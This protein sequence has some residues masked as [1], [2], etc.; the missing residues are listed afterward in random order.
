MQLW[1]GNH[2]GLLDDVFG[3]QKR[4]TGEIVTALSVE[5]GAAGPSPGDEHAPTPGYHTYLRALARYKSGTAV[6]IEASLGLFEEALAA[7]PTLAEAWAGLQTG[8]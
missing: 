8:R 3:I 7:D 5:L 6:D 4:I 1:A 2:D